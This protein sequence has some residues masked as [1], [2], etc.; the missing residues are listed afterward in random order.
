MCGRG[1]TTNQTNY[2]WNYESH[3][4]YE[5]CYNQKVRKIT[6]IESVNLANVRYSANL[7]LIDS[8]TLIRINSFNS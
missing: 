6:K 2:S 8:I 7:L 3:E 5:Y 1:E 4:L